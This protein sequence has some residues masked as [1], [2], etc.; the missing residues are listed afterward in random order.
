[1]SDEPIIPN[2]KP[3]EWN[4]SESGHPYAFQDNDGKTYLFFQGN[5][6]KGKTWYLSKM[7]VEWREGKLV[8]VK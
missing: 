6:D 8:L 5:N 4:S 7:R 1:M 3:G 2:G